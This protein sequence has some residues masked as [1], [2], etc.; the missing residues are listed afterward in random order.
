[1]D[2][3]IFSSFKEC[4]EHLE[5]Y[6]KIWQDNENIYFFYT[7]IKNYQEFANK[8]NPDKKL[9]DPYAKNIEFF[10]FERFFKKFNKNKNKLHSINIESRKN[11][12][13]KLKNDIINL[14]K[15][16]ENHDYNNE[17]I[18]F[19]EEYTN[20]EDYIFFYNKGMDIKYFGIDLVDLLLSEIKKSNIIGE[21]WFFNFF[22]DGYKENWDY[23]TF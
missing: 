21:E 17:Y 15:K 2:H 6:K 14:L 18:S 1:M 11:L 12:D 22:K 7:E 4:N 20:I 23:K 5:K 19:K 16:E 10:I 13:K 3:F 9:I 8:Y